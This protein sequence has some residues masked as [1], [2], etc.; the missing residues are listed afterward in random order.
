MTFDNAKIR[1]MK[2]PLRR[3]YA[4]R[5]FLYVSMRFYTLGTLHEIFWTRITRIF[6]HTD[7]TDLT[8]LYTRFFWTRII[9]IT[10]I[11]LHMDF[12]HGIFWTRITRIKRIFLYKNLRQ[13]NYS[14]Y[15]S[16]SCSKIFRVSS[17]LR[18]IMWTKKY[19]CYS[20]YSCSKKI[21]CHPC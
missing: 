3:F 7:L 19:S 14:C 21:E 18:S 15:S 20:S 11:F 10:R 6:L 9:R 16:F 1:N 4:I 13:Q 12:L 5:G 17:V 8:D 2:W